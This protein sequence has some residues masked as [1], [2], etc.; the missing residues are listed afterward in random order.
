MRSSPL[1]PSSPATYRR[2]G[3]S[4]ELVGS[5]AYPRSFTSPN[6]APYHGS[7]YHQRRR[8]VV[9]SDPP[10]RDAARRNTMGAT[11]RPVGESPASVSWNPEPSW[12]TS[13]FP[14]ASTLRG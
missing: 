7:N 13:L 11:R 14:S 10:T 3:N 1:I 4:R 8:Y 2:C 6:S 12:I 9:I 5:H